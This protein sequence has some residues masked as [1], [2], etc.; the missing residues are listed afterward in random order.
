[1]HGGFLNFLERM[2][3]GRLHHCRYCR[4]QFWDRRPLASEVAEK[5]REVPATSRPDTASSGE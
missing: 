2:A 1:M 5:P 3:S 4:L